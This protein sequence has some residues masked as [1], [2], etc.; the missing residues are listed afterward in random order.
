MFTSN[1]TGCH[2]DLK[3]KLQAGYSAPSLK[4]MSYCNY[5]SLSSVASRAFSVLCMY[6]KFRHHPHPLC[7]NFVSFAASIAQL[8]HGEKSRTQSLTQLAYSITHSP[9]LFDAPGTEAYFSELQRCWFWVYTKCNTC[10]TTHLQLTKILKCHFCYFPTTS[11]CFY[12][13]YAIFYLCASHAEEA[14]I[15][16]SDICPCVSPCVC[17]FTQNLKNYLETD[18]IW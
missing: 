6:L 10:I 9:S 5:F 18:K 15:T 12:F 1:V 13:P 2:Q 4:C 16:F 11:V 3:R 8:A 17:L 7:A 14:G